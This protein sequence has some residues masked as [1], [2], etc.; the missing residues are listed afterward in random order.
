LN[1]GKGKKL[2]VSPA[3]PDW[4][5]SPS[6]FLFNGYRISLSGAKRPGSQVD[7]S[8]APSAEVKNE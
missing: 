7:Q 2:L 5:D 8:A 4:P 1:S 6:S 3:F